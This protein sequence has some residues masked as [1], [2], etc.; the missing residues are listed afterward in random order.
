MCKAKVQAKQKKVCMKT[1]YEILKRIEEWEHIKFG[2]Y[3]GEEIA[4]IIYEL[5]WVL[6]KEHYSLTPTELNK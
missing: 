1:Q 2:K 3:S 4:T 6:D 5:K